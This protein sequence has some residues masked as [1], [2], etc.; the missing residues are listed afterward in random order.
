MEASTDSTFYT[1]N[2]SIPF[3]GRDFTREFQSGFMLI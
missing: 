1:D 2:N 3:K